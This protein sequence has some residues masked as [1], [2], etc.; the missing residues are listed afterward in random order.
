MTSRELRVL[1]E[2]IVKPF[3]HPDPMGYMTRALIMT[4]GDPDYIGMDGKR[5]FMPVDPSRALEEVG[6]SDVQS[7]QG[8]V[9]ATLTMDRMLFESYRTINDMI[10]AFHFDMGD[11][12]TW[13]SQPKYKSFIKDI[14]DS[15]DDARLMVYPP[16]ATVKD[17][18]K[19][20]SDSETDKRLDTT[21]LNFFKRLMRGN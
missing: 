18:I 11:E 13:E 9:I 1:Y 14:D 8:N 16:R 4:E 15:R 10:I 2:S 6:V 20:V 7:L 17:V 12:E 5:G 3:G 19:L 21:E